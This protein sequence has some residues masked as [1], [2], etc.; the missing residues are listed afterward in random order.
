M[1]LR[2]HRVLF[3]LLLFAAFGKSQEPA[4][5]QTPASPPATQAQQPSGTLRAPVEVPSVVNNGH[6]LSLDVIYWFGRS[7][8]ILSGG[9]ADPN[10]EPGN[11]N[12]I[13]NPNR[14]IGYRLSIP[15]GSNA[16]LRTSYVQT[17]STGFAI[18]PVNSVLFGQ[19]ITG[20]DLAATR[21]KIEDIKTSYEYLTYFWKKNSSEVR[22]KTL[23]ELQRISVTNEVDDFSLNNDGVTFTI[24]TATGSR[25]VFLPTF[26]LGL[27]YTMS[28]HLRI[29]A[30][31]TGFGLLHRGDIGDAEAT[32]AYRRGHIEAIG[33]YRLLHFKTNPKLDFYNAGTLSGP[34]VGLRFY[35][36]KQ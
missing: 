2:L 14:A 32:V 5:P 8:P 1:K 31:G 16:V 10:T 28:P 19:A 11:F 22:L 17:Q 26:G 15:I 6:G 4:S 24:N 7:R 33:G 21:Y 18:I 9:D 29:E 20:G 27:E 30:R 12:Y 3:C 35:W 13:T 34:Y 25:A 23:W 36:K